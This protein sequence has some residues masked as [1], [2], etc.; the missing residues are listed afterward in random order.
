MI[1]DEAVIIGLGMIGASLGAA[2]R[3]HASYQRIYGYDVDPHAVERALERGHITDKLRVDGS[4]GELRSMTSLII[5][6]MPIEATL[7]FIESHASSLAAGALVMDVGSTKVA[8]VDAMT[9]YIRPTVSAIGGHPMTGPVTMR[10]NTPS[11]DLFQDCTFVLTPFSG[12]GDVRSNTVLASH[13]VK[14]I[15]ARPVVMDAERHDRLVAFISHV[16]RL[17]PIA[18]LAAA[19]QQQDE[20]IWSLAAGSFREAT[21]PAADDLGFWRDVFATNT[22]GI[23]QALRA[24][25]DQIETLAQAVEQGDLALIE[26]LSAQAQA[27]WAQRY[28]ANDTP[29]VDSSSTASEEKPS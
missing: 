17:L 23:P 13:I 9:R 29:R 24:I 18:L 12:N 4:F 11:A 5:L 28:K 22:Q 19:R 27:D 1:H 10:T 7:H 20:L 25:S 3:Q 14:R 21:R 2:L 6:A 15:G 16:N 8:I 26:Q